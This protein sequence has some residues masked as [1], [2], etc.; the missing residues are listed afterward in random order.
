MGQLKLIIGL[1]TIAL[2]AFALIGFAEKFAVDNDAYVRLSDDSEIS[3]LSS[4]LEENLNEFGSD[5]EDSYASII[6]TTIAPESGA[7]QSTGPFAITPLNAIN[8]VKNIMEVGYVKIF[9][10][11]SGFGIFL[12]TL[13]A[14]LTFLVGLY[15]Y[16]TLR[17]MPD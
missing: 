15:I 12:G 7:A 10:A 17:G 13:I 16:K 14:T 2:F 5:A 8:V 9:G 6:D 1:I 3:G 11:G 4:D